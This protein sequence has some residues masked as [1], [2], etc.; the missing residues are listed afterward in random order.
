VNEFSLFELDRMT[1]M[2][3]LMRRK[4]ALALKQMLYTNFSYL[5]LR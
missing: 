3:E 5:F 4:R 1:D 2:L